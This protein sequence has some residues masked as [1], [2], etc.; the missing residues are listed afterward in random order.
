LEPGPSLRCDPMAKSVPRYLRISFIILS[1]GGFYSAVGHALLNPNVDEDY[2]RTYITGEFGAYPSSPIFNGSNPLLYKI[3]TIHRFDTEE[4][5]LLLS[6]FDWLTWRDGSSFLKGAN[7]RIFPKLEN[8]IIETSVFKATFG[9]KCS[10]PEKVSTH[11]SFSVSSNLVGSGVCNQEA[12]EF[13]FLI[14]ANLLRWNEY[15][16]IDVAICGVDLLER[17]KTRLGLRSRA[18][19]IMYFKIEP[20]RACP[21]KS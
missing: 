4:N 11:I 20:V 12:N 16:Q 19:E 5:Q 8:K 14:P 6:R 21:R 15:N 7:G 2:R 10:F 9:I 18:V 17:V 1:L 13:V 3:G